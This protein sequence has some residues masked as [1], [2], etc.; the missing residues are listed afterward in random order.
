M[1]SLVVRRGRDLAVTLTDLK[2]K[3]RTAVAGE[4]ADA[5]AGAVRDVLAAALIDRIAAV[6]SRARV[7]PPAWAKPGIDPDDEDDR[8]G[9]REEWD[10]EPRP[11]RHAPGHG[12]DAVEPTPAIPAAAA[13]ALGVQVG[14]WWLARR[15]TVPAAV[16]AGVL[17]TALG[18]A[19]GPL[20]RTGLAVLA[21]ATDLLNAEA[22]PAP[23]D[24]S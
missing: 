12:R 22:A 11:A 24:H 16:G 5:V 17:T 21:A 3:V 9:G 20:T 14:R 8:W 18:F 23:G 2:A 19:G 1:T 4:M 15:G 6:P 10:E 13:V 7:R